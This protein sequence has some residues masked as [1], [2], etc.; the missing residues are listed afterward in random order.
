MDGKLRDG[1]YV[2]DK[3]HNQL[4]RTPLQS[5]TYSQSQSKSHVYLLVQSITHQANT[6]S[7]FMSTRLPSSELYKLWRFRLGHPS[8]KVVQHVLSQC[9]IP[10]SMNKMPIEVCSAC[11]L[12]KIHK[13]PYLP[14][15]PINTEPLQLIHTDHW[16]PSPNVS[17][18]R[19][20]YYIS[21]VDTYSRYT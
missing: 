17:K 5:H 2:F 6:C 11:C 16:G 21:F 19:F 18:N 7:A 1:L 4:Q 20:K 13:F 8:C 10:F 3:E 12:G 15:E 14:S 9:N